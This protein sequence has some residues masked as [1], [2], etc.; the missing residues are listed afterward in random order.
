[1]TFRDLVVHV[2]ASEAGARRVTYASKIAQRFGAHLTGVYLRTSLLGAYYQDGAAVGALAPLPQSVIETY[3]DAQEAT[4][5]KARDAFQLTAPAGASW[6]AVDGDSPEAM[7]S[8]IRRTDLTIFPRQ[9]PPGLAAAGLEPSSLAM[10][11][12]RPMLLTP[13]DPPETFGRRILIAWN[14]GREAAR[15]LDDASPLLA[16]AESVHVLSVGE[17]GEGDRLLAAY[18]ERQ[19]CRPEF[20]VEKGRSDSA[21]EVILGHV[22]RLGCDLVVMGLYGH[23]RVRQFLLGGVSRAMLAVSPVPMFVAH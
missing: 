11:A 9:R 7:V 20:I 8:C 21:E 1:M 15:A 3:G 18:L 5:N 22:A 6:L 2:D 23:T 19:G 4:A 14:G 16:D 13:D 17:A 10:T 12:G